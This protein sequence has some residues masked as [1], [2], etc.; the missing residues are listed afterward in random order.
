MDG[1]GDI[2]FNPGTSDNI[3]R[4]MAWRQIEPIHEN[5]NGHEKTMR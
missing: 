5:E 4:T 3:T 1:E 2:S